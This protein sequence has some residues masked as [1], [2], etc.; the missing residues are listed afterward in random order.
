MGLATVKAL[1]KQGWNV[2]VVDFNSEKGQAVAAELG[3]AVLFVKTNVAIYEDQANAFRQTWSRWS[4]LDLGKCI[5]IRIF[6][7]FA[8]DNGP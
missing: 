6:R 7:F 3:D 4:R 2:A 8:I 1:V 5:H